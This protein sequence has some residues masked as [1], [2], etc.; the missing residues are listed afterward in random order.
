MWA[1]LSTWERW[2]RTQ[3]L[4]SSPPSPPPLI[5]ELPDI[6]VKK[7]K[8]RG[9]VYFNIISL[10]SLIFHTIIITIIKVA[11]RI[12]DNLIARYGHADTLDKFRKAPRY[13]DDE[14]VLETLVKI[15]K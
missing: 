4:P 10:C 13:D 7:Y 6:L 3:A 11:D 14:D 12:T 5:G 8:F 1:G 2:H 9:D 15:C